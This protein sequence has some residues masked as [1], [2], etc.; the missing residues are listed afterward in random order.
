MTTALNNLAVRT[1]K[2]MLVTGIDALRLELQ[3]VGITAGTSELDD[4]WSAL[5][6]DERQAHLAHWVKTPPSPKVGYPR[7]GDSWPLWVVT[8]GNETPVK[9]YLGY[10]GEQLEEAEMM[11]TQGERYRFVERDKITVHIYILSEN[12]DVCMLHYRAARRICQ[13]GYLHLINRGFEEPGLQGQELA[14]DPRYS[15][16]NIFTRRLILTVETD[17]TWTDQTPLWEA[18][19]GPPVQTADGSLGANQLRPIIHEDVGGGV[20]PIDPNDD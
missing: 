10:I 7:D 17:D 14:P 3:T 8:L 18:L 12:A 20:H 9:D 16:D 1:V 13:V 11:T 5:P 15:P 6:D 4:V 2:E 19:N